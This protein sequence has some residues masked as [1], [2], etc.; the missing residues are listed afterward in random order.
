M[1]LERV[2]E[3]FHVIALGIPVPTFKGHTLD[4]P[5]RSR[6][7]CRNVTQLPFETMSRL[8]EFLAPNVEPMRL[9]N[10]L[11]LAYA[12]NSQAGEGKS[13]GLP[14]FPLDSL[15]HAVRVWVGY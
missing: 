13:L 7:Q 6:F 5:L 1:K 3:D 14:L 15:V 2:S 4:P 10:V 9:N 11:A 12:L 8:C